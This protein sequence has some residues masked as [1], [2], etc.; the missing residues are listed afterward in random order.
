MRPIF[1]VIL[2]AAIPV[3]GYG[4]MHGL[5]LIL[6]MDDGSTGTH[7]LLTAAI[8]FLGLAVPYWMLKAGLISAHKRNPKERELQLKDFPKDRGQMLREQR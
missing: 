8:I 3:L 1:W 6:P 2:A 4:V 5:A 7:L